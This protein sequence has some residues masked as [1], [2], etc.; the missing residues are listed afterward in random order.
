MQGDA[1]SE[2][3]IHVGQ[4]GQHPGDDARVGHLG[5]LKRE[6]P[7]LVVTFDLAQAVPEQRGLAVV[8]VEGLGPLRTLTPVTG[9][10]KWRSCRMARGRAEGAGVAT[11]AAWHG[12]RAA[13]A[14]KRALPIVREWHRGSGNGIWS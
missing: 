9:W 6:G 8:V 12:Q 4:I 7:D 11:I 5:Q 10:G 1:G 2:V 14:L 13:V 3:H